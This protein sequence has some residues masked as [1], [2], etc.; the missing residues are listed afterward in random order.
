MSGTIIIEGLEKLLPE[1]LQNIIIQIFALRDFAF[2][3]NAT[4]TSY[5]TVSGEIN[6][7]VNI[8]SGG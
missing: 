1:P 7:N 2:D 4:V 6:P 8:T 5:R 3:S